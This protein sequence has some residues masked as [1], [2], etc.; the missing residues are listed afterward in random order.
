V[1]S[2]RR[3][4]VL[5]TGTGV[6]K[7]WVTTTL[8]RALHRCGASVVAL[9]P[10]ETG[11][12]VSESSDAALLASASS[13]APSAPPFVFPDPVSP[14]LAARRFGRAIDIDVVLEHVKR[15]ETKLEKSVTSHVTSF[16]IVET[17][18]GCLTPLAP[19][20]VNRDLAIALEP[21]TW[22]LVAPDALGVLHDVSATLGALAVRGRVPD[23]V[24]LSEARERDASTGTNGPELRELGIATPV[25]VAARGDE[26]SLDDFARALIA[27]PNRASTR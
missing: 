10:I 8:A 12:E 21:A 22:I 15:H 1:T 19:G 25:A 2:T 27:E 16:L 20:V 26:Q 14:H 7:T 9:K 17:A 23:H 3:I 18:G 4:I 24:V 13:T 5:G 6:G 11:V